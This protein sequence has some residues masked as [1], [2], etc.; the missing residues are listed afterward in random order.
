M[1][2]QTKAADYESELIADIGGFTHDPLGHVLYVYPWGVK[3][4]GLEK[5]KGPRAWQRARLES[6]GEKLRAG[7]AN[8]GEVIQEAVASG[9]GIGK[10]ALVAW[11]IKWAMDTFEDTRGTVTANTE[12]QLRTK[13]WPEVTK[14]HNL[15]LTKHWFTITATSMYSNEKGHEQSWRF[16]AAP[17]SEHNTEA[18]AGLHN[19]GKRILL[20]FDEASKIAN[21]VWEVAEG[22]LTDSNTE[23]IWTAFGNPTQT[24]GRFRDCFGKL[25]HR[26]T[27]V[28]IDSRTVEGTNKVQLDKMVADYGEDSDVVKVRIR[29]MFPA[30]SMTQF[31]SL[32]D[33]DKA[34]GKHLRPD[35]Y[36]FA[37]KILT[38]DNAWTGADEGVIGL[39]QG[40]AFKILRTFAKNDND[41]QIGSLLAAL[42]DEHDAD[43]VF[44]DGGYGTGVYSYGT[45]IGRSWVLVW[46]SEKS[47][48]A[49]C[50]NK[51][52]EMW[53]GMRDWL[54]AGGAIPEDPVLHA[55]LIGPETLP[56][57]DGKIVLESKEDMKDRGLPSPGR[58]DAL[59]LSFA[60]PVTLKPRGLEA[61]Y[62]GRKTSWDY[63]PLS[64]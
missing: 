43:A 36:N 15:S 59:A 61:Q 19:E 3:G 50:L 44:I 8:L 56:R 18:F 62:G 47:M 5:H 53:K 33:V 37:P 27:G 31:I 48:D 30:M 45:T 2:A 28:Q 40:L 10:S 12:T 4:G 17:W 34:Y 64:P 38:L 13:T 42:E 63:D 9:H 14:W 35:Q 6:I 49:G 41:L 24:T 39:R 52:S 1:S 54:K 29:G 57:P 23:I 60:H 51:R 32:D 26:W 22:A 25:R 20:V 46:F 55:D 58:G 21:K 7:S 16:D 11:L